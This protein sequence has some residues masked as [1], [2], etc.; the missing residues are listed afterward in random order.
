M[1][2]ESLAFR[3]DLELLRLSGSEVEDHGSYVAVRTPDNPTY[4]WGNFLLLPHAPTTEDLPEWIERFGATYPRSRHLAFG[5]DGPDGTLDDLEP[6]R[7]AGL[8]VDASSV[9]TAT[10]V[11]EPARPNLE[12]TYRPLAGDD[13]WHQ[14]LELGIAGEHEESGRDFVVA[15]T[16]SERALSGRGIGTWWG[17]FIGDRLLASMGLF[18][19]S[20]GLARFQ[21]VKTHP[22]AR[23]RGLAGT[24]VHRVSQYGFAELDART[25]VM[26]ADPDY[27]A[28]RI[29]RS[30][31]FDSTE[32][33]L[34]AER[35]P[36]TD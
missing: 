19:V 22:D 35:K 18:A 36:A 32:T 20:P 24:L 5:V 14:Q 33:Q 10:A 29:Y 27:L 6:F 4:Y 25:L 30:V 9:M 3:T 28:I 8:D 26:V 23:G 11:H 34:Q 31:G 2:V 13:D 1:H 15:K 7:V 17:A 12:A 16:A 21:Q